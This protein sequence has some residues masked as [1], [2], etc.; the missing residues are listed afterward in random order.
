M[1]LDNIFVLVEL[2]ANISWL[3]VKMYGRKALLPFRM[4]TYDKTGIFN[5]PNTRLS[6]CQVGCGPNFSCIL[7]LSHIDWLT[8]KNLVMWFVLGKDL[9]LFP[10]A[11]FVS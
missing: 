4:T 9:L 8:K 10:N 1:D 6:I 2:T 7:I 5:Q 3:D 11:K